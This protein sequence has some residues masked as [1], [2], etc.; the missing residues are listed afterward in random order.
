MSS[1]VLLVP[2]SASGLPPKAQPTEQQE[3]Q[4]AALSQG[5]EEREAE[6]SKACADS[7]KS[8]AEG[9]CGQLSCLLGHIWDPPLGF[10]APLFKPGCP[11]VLLEAGLATLTRAGWISEYGKYWV[12]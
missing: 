3:K 2:L 8:G 10:R 1:P 9:S 6:G 12:K 4:L 7:L 5:S 11:M